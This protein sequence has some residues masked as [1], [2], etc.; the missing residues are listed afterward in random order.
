[1]SDVFSVQTKNFAE[2]NIR[3]IM[4]AIPREIANDITGITTCCLTNS[5]QSSV[6]LHFTMSEI[7]EWTSLII[8]FSRLSEILKLFILSIIHFKSTTDSNERCAMIE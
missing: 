5:M 2:S 6:V 7:N 4:N 1:M 8:H 3:L